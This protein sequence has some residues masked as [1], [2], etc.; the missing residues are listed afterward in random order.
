MAIKKQYVRSQ[1]TPLISFDAIDALTNLG[2]IH[3]KAFGT[4]DETARGY[5]FGTS[6]IYS[7]P[8]GTTSDNFDQTSF[9]LEKTISFD[10]TA[11][12]T[13]QTMLGT[14][15]INGSFSVQAGAGSNAGTGNV[16]FLIQH[17]SGATVTSIGNVT[18]KDLSAASASTEILTFC[19]ELTLTKTLFKIGDVIRLKANI[20]GK[21]D[22]TGTVN[23]ATLM[24]D[25]KNRDSGVFTAATN[26]TT[27]DVYIPFKIIQ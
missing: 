5:G 27:L 2:I 15:R 23:T 26:P 25:P 14:V 7:Q 21:K 3:F 4:E 16:E 20:F 1:E 6:D 17:V 11:L 24:H 9:T 18:T 10:S 12:A 22:D 8:A 13:A 19:M